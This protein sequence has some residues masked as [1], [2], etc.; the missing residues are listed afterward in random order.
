[1]TLI[2]DRDYNTMGEGLL[3]AQKP[4]GNINSTINVSTID[5]DIA[6]A[7]GETAAL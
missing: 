7:A 2:S 5:G 6:T 4:G 3:R 1:M